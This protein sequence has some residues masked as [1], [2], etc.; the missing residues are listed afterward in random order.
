MHRNS[1]PAKYLHLLLVPLVQAK[2][3]IDFCV[4]VHIITVNWHKP[5]PFG[6]RKWLDPVVVIFFKNAKKIT[7]VG[8]SNRCKFWN[9]L[10]PTLVIFFGNEKKF[11]SKKITSMGSKH[12]LNP[13]L[14][15]FLHFWKKLQQLDQVIF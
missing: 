8:W 3:C 11:I 7:S 9:A 2:K 10:D 15:F 1:E 6:L 4:Y 5:C 13:T 12:Q 14:E